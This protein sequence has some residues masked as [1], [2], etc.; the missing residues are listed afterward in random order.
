MALQTRTDSESI[1]LKEKV[2][3]NLLYIGIFSIMMLFAGLTSAYIVSQADLKGPE[4]SLPPMFWY[5]SAVILISSVTMNFTV[6]SAR[7]NK[8]QNAKIGLLITLLLGI[9]FGVFQYF[10]WIELYNSGIFFA[11]KKSFAPGSFV[12]VMSGLH[13]L[14]VISG[15]VYM[16]VVM[17]KTFSQGYNSANYTGLKLCGIYWHFL[18]IL[19]IYLFVFLL[20]I[21]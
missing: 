6:S 14:H 20:V 7:K 16:L 4:F 17:P 3:K 2:F 10:G 13:L 11:G 18:D 9:L 12:Y 8:F 5:S 19:W 21:R 1:A 15:L